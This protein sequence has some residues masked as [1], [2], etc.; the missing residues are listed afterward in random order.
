VSWQLAL[1]LQCIHEVTLHA[2]C[3]SCSELLLLLLP[4]LPNVTSLSLPIPVQVC[5]CVPMQKVTVT[6]PGHAFAHHG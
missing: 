2:W 5:N 6:L 3:G 1:A 4:L